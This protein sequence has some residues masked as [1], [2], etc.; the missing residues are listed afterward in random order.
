MLAGMKAKHSRSTTV[1]R[2]PR[3]QVGVVRGSDAIMPQ[4]QKTK[5]FKLLKKY[6][7]KEPSVVLAFLFG[8]QAKELTHAAS[9]W[10]IGVYFRPR[11]YVEL[12]TEEEY[13]HEHTMWRDVARIVEREVDFVV[14]NR[15]RPSLV[16]NV[17]RTGIPLKTQDKKLYF[18]LLC[19][20]SYEA[21]DWWDFVSDYFQISEKA[22]SISKEAKTKIQERLI[23]TREQFGDIE[24]FR[25]LTWLNYRDDR[26]ER[27][28]VERWVENLVM[29]SLDIAK[30]ILAAEKREIP[31]SYKDILKVFVAIYIDPSIAE[32]FSRFAKLRNIVAHEYLDLRWKRIENFIKE[33]EKLYPRFIEK[34]KEIIK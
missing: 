27:R 7:E 24:R 19:K 13:P 8:S 32:E 21:M 16:Y 18:D 28:N 1:P 4:I 14:L 9:D 3:Q 2:T 29:A 22:K 11:E 20:V 10:D 34:T 25:K 6:F 12:E 17:L 23:F 30:I 33:A 5:K 26:N 15:A 31:Q